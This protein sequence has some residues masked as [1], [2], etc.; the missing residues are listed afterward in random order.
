MQTEMH[1]KFI[2]DI[3]L[4]AVL[5]RCITLIQVFFRTG[6]EITD[7]NKEQLV[8]TVLTSVI[9]ILAA[10]P[11]TI[12]FAG[13]IGMDDYDHFSDVIIL[14]ETRAEQRF[15]PL[16]G[17]LNTRDIGGYPAGGN[18]RIREGM[19]YRSD[20]LSMLSDR[21]LDVLENKGLASVIDLREKS[22]KQKYPDMM[23]EGA[24][25]YWFPV[26]D[27]TKP[28]HI[29]LLFRR[30]AISDAF[31]Q[32]YIE[33]IEEWAERLKPVF[34]LLAD[35]QAYPVLI[36]CTSGKDRVGV[37][38]ALLMSVLGVPEPYIVSDFSLSNM[39]LSE[40][41]DR[42]IEHQEGGMLLRVGI[43]RDDFTEIMGVRSQWMKY[44]LDYLS[45]NYGTAENYLINEV[46]L[47]ENT[48]EEIR[49]L[50]LTP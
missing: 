48:I 2:S 21:D 49:E 43:P 36:H 19:L 34:T 14:E 38:T 20:D 11:I 4:P 25:Y 8:R 26:Y 46:G 28:L 42:F 39:H 7:Q 40:A 50:L 3:S 44:F 12:R 24:Q 29:P 47:S 9:I 18:T 35:E 32:G 41:V 33:Y 23:P 27:H 30:S 6:L 1:K 5:F 10:I 16:E 22:R 13:G 17:T 45:R 37:V 31:Q 15:L